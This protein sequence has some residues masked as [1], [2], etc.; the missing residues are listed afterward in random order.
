MLPDLSY[1]ESSDGLKL[2]YRDSGG[3]GIPLLCLSGLTRNSTDFSYVAPYLDGTRLITLDYRGRGASA[4]AKDWQTYSIPV[5]ARDVLELLAHLGLEEVAILGTSR[6]GLIAMALAA[7][8][9]ER[10]LGV[11]LNDIGPEISEEGMDDIKTYLGEKPA[12]ATLQDAAEMRASLMP[13][14]DNVPEG[15]W[16]DEVA[17]HYVETDEGL[18]INYDPK[19]RDAVLAA[20]EQPLPDLW[21]LFEALRGLPVALIRGTNSN[22][23]TM[24]TTQEMQKRLPEMIF[25]NVP[26]RGHVPFLD[27]PESLDALNE[28]LGAL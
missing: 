17:L 25:A 10:L 21:P 5:E 22:L 20:A 6:G 11:C 28:W 27:E 8:A 19:L 13:G 18:E 14:F 26:D 16:E 9:K 2:A 1:F 7:I 23:L 15:R 3:D 12:A 4:W 24:E